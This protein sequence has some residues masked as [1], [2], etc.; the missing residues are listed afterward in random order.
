MRAA[1]QRLHNAGAHL[2][3]MV[4]IELT[5]GEMRVGDTVLSHAR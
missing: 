3:R 4:H 2:K 1:Q 5:L